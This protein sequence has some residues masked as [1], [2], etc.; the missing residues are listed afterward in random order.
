MATENTTQTFVSPISQMHA[1]TAN[2]G[3]PVIAGKD[4]SSE[5]KE[6]LDGFFRGLLSTSLNVNGVNR[7]STTAITTATIPYGEAEAIGYKAQLAWTDAGKKLSKEE[8]IKFAA[9]PLD[10]WGKIRALSVE[11]QLPQGPDIF[12]F[13]YHG[14]FNVSPAQESM[15]CRMRLP[16]GVLK[17]YQLEGIANAA[18]NF[19]G[20]YAHIT[21]RANFQI[22]EIPATGME[23]LL[24][25]LHEVGIVPRGSGADN[26]RNVT[27]NPTAGI[28]K[29][30]F[31]D[32]LPLCKELHHY[33]LNH[34]EM[35]GLPRKFNVAFDGGNSIAALEETND[36]GF[37]A[38]KVFSGAGSGHEFA[39]GVYFRVALG[40]ITGHKDFARDTGLL[41]KPEECLPVTVAMIKVFIANGDRGQRGKARLKYV[42]DKWGFA[43]FLEETQKLLPFPLNYLA[44]EK[45]EFAPA[46]DKLAHVGI[47]T[48]KQKGLSYIGIHTPVGRL[49][50]KQMRDLASIAQQF[51]SGT[52]RL[53]VWQNLILSD[54]SNSQVPQALQALEAAGFAYQ[55]NMV[56]AGLVSCTGAEGCKF[57][58]AATKSTAV[59][60]AEYLNGKVD[61]DQPVNIHLTGCPHSCAQHYIGDI[62]LLATSAEVNGEKVGAF[63]IYVGGG[64]AAERGIARQ[65]MKAIPITTLPQT[66]EFVLKTY[67]QKR[68]G[69]ESFAA[70]TQQLEET[71]LLTMFTL[72][73]A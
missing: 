20:G 40:G 60:L 64:Y 63:H 14:L 72:A 70:F 24:T 9:N 4:F 29:Q 71:D 26:I 55:P 3:S 5:Q 46:I 12:H 61:L 19:G 43:K 62:G 53:T 16:G 30:E 57:G 27:G 48:Q 73:Q 52:I 13:K 39:T 66:L 47:H 32:V 31:Y 34:R 51:G 11:G 18:E 67:L 22:R 1:S 33:I 2:Q 69:S 21:T 17:S 50:V 65:I 42:L 59:V 45:C 10:S 44:A 41:L 7:N 6:Y 25:T 58:M 36:I 23:P 54:I 15:M 28:D 8:Q 38:V 49:S 68:K 56:L 35:Y 37:K